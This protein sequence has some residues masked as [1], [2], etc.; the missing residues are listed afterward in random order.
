MKNVKYVILGMML[1]IVLLFVFSWINSKSSITDEMVGSDRYEQTMRK[2][3]DQIQETKQMLLLDADQKCVGEIEN[4]YN[5]SADMYSKRSIGYHH[6]IDWYHNIS[7]KND[8]LLAHYT[9]IFEACNLEEKDRANLAANLLSSSI[10]FDEIG[11]KVYYEHE[12]RISYLSDL[13]PE[14]DRIRLIESWETVA[15]GIEDLLNIVEE[16]YE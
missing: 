8:G 15:N 4:L 6:F 9:K 2:N 1:T 10:F 16:R 14:I 12:L 5:K 11:A 13:T 7:S 3:K